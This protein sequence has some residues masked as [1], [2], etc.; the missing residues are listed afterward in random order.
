MLGWWHRRL[1]RGATRS[2]FATQFRL[3]HMGDIEKR[4]GAAAMQMLRHNAG[5][6]LHRQRIAGEAH[7]APAQFAVQR[8]ERGFRQG[9]G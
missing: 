5:G 1:S 6:V 3:A 9:F 7:H 4:C 8:G 2:T